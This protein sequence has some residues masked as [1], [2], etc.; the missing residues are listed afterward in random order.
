MIS[1]GVWGYGDG[2]VR[3]FVGLV[4]VEEYL[5]FV[6]QTLL[7]GLTYLVQ[8]HDHLPGGVG[9]QEAAARVWGS[10][11]KRVYLLMP[12]L[13]WITTVAFTI[14]GR[15]FYLASLL[16]CTIPVL[17]F[18]WA[19][20]GVHAAG[21][22]RLAIAVLLPTVYLLVADVVALKQGIW[23]ISNT[24]TIGVRAGLLPLEE[25]LFFLLSNTMIVQGMALFD[26]ASLPVSTE[27]ADP[28]NPPRTDENG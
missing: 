13:L 5:F 26:F 24:H 11:R 17:Y 2:A 23:W 1:R 25:V 22:R 9:F 16:A 28:N 27:L 8:Q 18:Q 10:G 12:A 15:A 21:P 20:G 7:V 14:S 3:A 6:L 19:V 4:P